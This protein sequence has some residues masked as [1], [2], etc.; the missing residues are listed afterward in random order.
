MKNK[1]IFMNKNEVLEARKT[2][3][4][5]VIGTLLIPPIETDLFLNQDKYYIK[6]NYE[7]IINL[8]EFGDLIIP[9]KGKFFSTKFT[10]NYSLWQLGTNLKIGIS[11]T[12]IDLQGAFVADKND[13]IS[14]LW[15]EQNVP[16][17][18]I[19][20]GFIFYTWSFDS[21]DLYQN[22]LEREKFIFGIRH[23]HFRA[24]KIIHDECSRMKQ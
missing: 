20:R 23:M 15:G 8:P 24:M 11:I 22:Y 7:N 17:I 9:I 21:P 3:F 12:D 2:F 4:S 16:K 18:D 14:E 19:S 10:L 13:E 5:D 1:G 6:P